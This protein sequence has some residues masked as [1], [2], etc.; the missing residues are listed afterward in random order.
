[1]ALPDA[2]VN[3]QII[4]L[5][6]HVV[7]GFNQSHWLELGVMTNHLDEVENHSRLLRSLGFGDEDYDGH[8]FS[9]LRKMV[10]ADSGN[11][12]VIAEYV[13]SN[14]PEAG[15][16]ISS[17]D[18]SMRRIVFSP[19][20]FRVPAGD[21]DTSL[22]SAMMP[23][24][25]D[26]GAVYDSIKSASSTTGFSCKRADDIWDDSTIIQ[27]IFSLIFRSYIV[28]CDFSRK[29]PNVFYEAGLAH[30]LG[31]HVIPIT[32]SQE[33]IPSDLRHHRYILYLNNSEGR[34]ELEGKLAERFRTLASKRQALPWI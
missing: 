23:F 12:A 22:V 4:A 25:G 7:A 8:A 3:K 13:R 32:Q 33:D 29:N 10:E 34:S 16:F 26:F 1:M 19:I 21:V 11:L 14:C 17:E 28:V 15:E 27:D 18:G 5:K 9:M 2:E 6:N 20:V 30:A 31:K 24:S